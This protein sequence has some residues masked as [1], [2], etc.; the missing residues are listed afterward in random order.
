MPVSFDM[1]I[2]IPMLGTGL[3]FVIGIIYQVSRLI[4]RVEGAEDKAIELKEHHDK[5][6]DRLDL[7]IQ[8]LQILSEASTTLRMDMIKGY[9]S[10]TH[11]KD[12]ERKIDDLSSTV[13]KLGATQASQG[14]TLVAIK[15]TLDDVKDRLK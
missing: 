1:T 10:L 9:A 15:E 2:S 11:M 4:T 14:A 7:Q 13:A 12:V 3:V 5:L 6:S 8:A